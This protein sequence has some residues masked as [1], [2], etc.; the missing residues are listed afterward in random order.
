MYRYFKR[1]VNSEYI[2]S[3]KS[4]GLSDESITPPSA[5]HYFLN[6]SLYY[7]GTTTRVRF[8]GSCLKQDTIRYNHGK[9][10]NIHI[11]YEINKND[12]TTS[13]DPTLE[14]CLFGAASLTK[15][16]DIDMHKHSGYRIGFDRKGNFSFGNGVGRNVI[17]F[18]V[19]MSSSIMIDIKKKDILILGKG[20]TP[21]LGHIHCLQKKS[22][23]LILLK[24][25]KIPLEFAL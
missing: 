9:I 24:K 10:A 16:S 21:G 8:S 22:I 5:P 12:N 17:I 11:V 14:N 25:I 2:L 19:D 20:S 3:W 6:P 1:V 15:N 18:E 4:K 13:S 23:Q 7:L